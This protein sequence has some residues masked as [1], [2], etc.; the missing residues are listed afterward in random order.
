MV[1]NQVKVLTTR[2]NFCAALKIEVQQFGSHS[3]RSAEEVGHAAS[4]I[5]D[6]PLLSLIIA[7]HSLLLTLRVSSGVALDCGFFLLTQVQF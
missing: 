7:L 2:S 3:S 6:T 1:L 5:S 4:K